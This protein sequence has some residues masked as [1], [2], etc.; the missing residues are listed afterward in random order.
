[1]RRGTTRKKGDEGV[2]SRGG[3]IRC[4]MGTNYYVVKLEPAS[5]RALRSNRR[6]SQ[7]KGDDHRGK[8][9]RERVTAIPMLQNQCYPIDGSYSIGL[10]LASR[11]QQR[12]SIQQVEYNTFQSIDL[13]Q[14]NY[15]VQC[16]YCN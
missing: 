11:M 6:F 5:K 10:H 15:T 7:A 16:T 4:H 9:R 13:T 14:H 12:N 3:I 1:M 8:R 2:G